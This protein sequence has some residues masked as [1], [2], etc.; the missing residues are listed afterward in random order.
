MYELK[1][2]GKFNNQKL[3]KK[4]ISVQKCITCIYAYINNFIDELRAQLFTKYELK[5]VGKLLFIFHT[6]HIDVIEEQQI[7]KSK[8]TH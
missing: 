3:Q 6:R 8:H 4:K 5:Y 7:N 1:Y 2:V